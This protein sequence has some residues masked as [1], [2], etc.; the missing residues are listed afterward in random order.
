MRPLYVLFEFKEEAW[1][2][3]N[4]KDDGENWKIK[5]S[6][7][8][9]LEKS[10]RIKNRSCECVLVCVWNFKSIKEEFHLF[11]KNMVLNI[12]LVLPY[13]LLYHH[14]LQH[15]LIILE[16]NDPIGEYPHYYTWVPLL[17]Y[18]RA[19]FMPILWKII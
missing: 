4:V 17:L 7:L 13:C 6:P 14:C 11:G 8:D 19:K 5:K 15:N 18:F 16:Y 9:N 1:V 2:W 3:F 10:C 12:S